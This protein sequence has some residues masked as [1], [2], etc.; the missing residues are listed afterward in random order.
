MLV[1]VL[2]NMRTSVSLSIGPLG[3]Q[4]MHRKNWSLYDSGLAS[5]QVGQNM[6]GLKLLSPSTLLPSLTSV[7]NWVLVG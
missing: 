3:A 6:E 2:D 1:S 7:R 5:W 4:M